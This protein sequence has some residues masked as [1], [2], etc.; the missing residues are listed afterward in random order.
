MSFYIEEQDALSNIL[1]SLGLKVEIYAHGEVCGRWAVDTS[2]NKRMPFHLLANGRTW[3]HQQ[4]KSATLLSA[5]D[6]VLFPRDVEHVISSEQTRP[7]Q[8]L[9]SE[10]EQ[11]IRCNIDNA[12]SSEQSATTLICGAFEFSNKGAWPLLDALPESVLMDV[13]LQSQNLKLRKLVELLVL[14]LEQRSSG[15]FVAIN[16]IAHLIFVEILRN[17]MQQGVSDGLLSALAD[18]QIGKALNLIHGSSQTA[19][20]IESLAQQVAMSRSVF[21]ALFKQKTNMTPIKYLTEWRMRQARELLRTSQRSIDDIAEALGYSSEAS[22]R[23]AFKFSSE[24]SPSQY[25]KKQC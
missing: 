12:P 8:S 11:A 19:W 16:H 22:F 7:E 10:T 21:A 20:T 23:K 25:R 24:C 17:Q 6:L 15:C 4:D 1:E 14:E 5:G 3:L 2:G 9:I 13:S 18:P